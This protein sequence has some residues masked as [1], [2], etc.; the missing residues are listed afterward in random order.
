MFIAFLT[1]GVI[2]CLTAD[3]AYGQMGGHFV[4]AEWASFQAM[5][6]DPAL[7]EYHAFNEVSGSYTWKRKADP[8]SKDLDP[9]LCRLW[10]IEA[11]QKK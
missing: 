2:G 5:P 9:E 1:C 3:A 7:S 4:Q 8:T 10:Q 11:V 6:V